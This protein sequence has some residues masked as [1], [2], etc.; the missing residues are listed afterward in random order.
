M[1]S[2]KVSLKKVKNHSRSI[3]V[4]CLFRVRII[5][6]SLSGASIDRLPFRMKPVV[7]NTA[8]T[9]IHYAITFAVDHKKIKINF[10]VIKTFKM[11]AEYKTVY[12]LSHTKVERN[13]PNK[14]T[15]RGNI[16]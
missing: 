3:I 4:F 12:C 10:D 14:L 16:E 15:F 7:E 5:L 1:K 13:A 6:L 11:G 9:G 2:M 8:S